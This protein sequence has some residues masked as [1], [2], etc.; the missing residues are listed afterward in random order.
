MQWISALAVV[1][2]I[3]GTLASALAGWEW[4]KLAGSLCVLVYVLL[5]ARFVIRG[6]WLMLASCS[7][8]SLLAL[9]RLPNGG[10]VL[11]KALGDG[12]YIIAL[13]AALSLLRDASE[14]SPLVLQCGQ[15]MVRQPPGRRYQVLSWGTHILS[16]VLNFGILPL[17]GGMV[18]KGNTLAAAG[19]DVRVAE[20]RKQRMLTAILRGYAMMTV[21]SPLSV[22][23]AVTQ[24]AVTGLPWWHLLPLQVVLTVIFM[25]LGWLMDRRAF[26][27]S[28]RS[29]LRSMGDEPP[30]SWSPAIRL[31]LL[32]AVVVAASLAL[33]AL[34][35]QRPV[36]GAMQV[37]PVAAVLWL[38]VQHLELGLGGALVTALR[39]FAV[40]LSI[41]MPGFRNEF[42]MLGGAMYFGTVLAAF[43]SPEAVAGLISRLSLPTPLLTVLLAWAMLLLA[44]YGISQIVTVTLLGG[45]L[46]NLSHMG[47]NPLVLASGLMGAWALSACTTPV[48][49]AA[50]TMAR[51]GEVTVQTVS[52]DWNGKFSFVGA[53]VLAL[54]MLVLGLL[55]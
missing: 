33:A 6:G 47:I 24:H 12:S 32:V 2:T 21:W 26:P 34:Q 42:V 37:V 3:A 22:S 5:E 53:G 50:L 35:G 1:A 52:R 14:S 41:S 9:W 49:A 16:L 40:R 43:V 17:L 4:A 48:G 51:I 31:T 11:L 10:D 55:V 46:A 36:I 23:F 39:R 38:T 54:W 7:A 45:A 28:A 29:A 30:P 25:W 44:R 15:L 13:F 20:I 27:P 19:G 18:M 8:I